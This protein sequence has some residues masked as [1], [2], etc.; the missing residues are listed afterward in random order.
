VLLLAVYTQQS[1]RQKALAFARSTFPNLD[2]RPEFRAH[3]RQLMGSL[4]YANTLAVSPYSALLSPEHWHTAAATLAH[5][6]CT[7]LGLPLHSALSTAVQAG[8]IAAPVLLKMAAVAA[9]SN[10]RWDQEQQLLIDVPL[11]H[12]LKFHSVFSCP[13]SREVASPNN[14]PVL[15]KCGH[16]ISRASMTRLPRLGNR[17]KCPTCPV[18]TSTVMELVLD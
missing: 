7:A 9:D 15:L 4:L 17:F 6:G 12:H 13:V 5:D 10:R 2:T 16:V 18:E 11:P 14:P 8:A 3:L 1:G